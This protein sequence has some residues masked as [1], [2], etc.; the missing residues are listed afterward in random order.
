MADKRAS[1]GESRSSGQ[2]GYMSKSKKEHPGPDAAKKSAPKKSADE[3]DEPRPT[4]PQPKGL[5][6]PRKSGVTPSW[7]QSKREELEKASPPPPTQSAP[8]GSLLPKGLVGE[9]DTERQRREQRAEEAREGAEQQQQQQQ[10]NDQAIQAGSSTAPAAPGTTEPEESRPTPFPAY[11]GGNTSALNSLAL[12]RVLAAGVLIFLLV[13]F[14]IFYRIRESIPE[15]APQEFN[16]NSVSFVVT[17][18]TLA[19]VGGMFYNY[20]TLEKV[21][22]EHERKRRVVLNLLRLAIVVIGFLMQLA[23]SQWKYKKSRELG[24]PSYFVGIRLITYLIIGIMGIM[25][26]KITNKALTHGP[27]RYRQSR[28]RYGWP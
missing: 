12:V 26:A 8:L 11:K 3:D 16:W 15:A 1:G 14:L 13:L 20:A 10:G 5:L 4:S 24:R 9:T 27:P 22:L 6:G 2:K 21:R 28:R 25:S 17:P 7:R 23:Y 19:T 18:L